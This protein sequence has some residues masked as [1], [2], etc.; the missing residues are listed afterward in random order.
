MLYKKKSLNRNYLRSKDRINNGVSSIPSEKR[1]MPLNDKETLEMKRRKVIS[2][3]L[4]RDER[5]MFR[6]EIDIAQ[7]ISLN[8]KSGKNKR[9]I[10]DVGKGLENLNERK[11]KNYGYRGNSTSTNILYKPSL[12][13]IDDSF[14][15]GEPS[16]DYDGNKHGEKEIADYYEEFSCGIQVEESLGMVDIQ[17]WIRS[18]EVKELNELNNRKKEIC[19]MKIE[20]IILNDNSAEENLDGDS[21]VELWFSSLEKIQ[22]RITLSEQQKDFIQSCFISLLPL[23]Y[24]EQFDINIVRLTKRFGIDAIFKKIFFE[25]PRRFGKTTST[26]IV[27]ATIAYMIP[28]LVVG[29]YSVVK[30][31]SDSLVESV[32][33][34]YETISG[35]DRLDF[36]KEWDKR[37]GKVTMKNAHGS[38]STVWGYS[39][40]SSVSYCKRK[41]K[42]ICFFSCILIYFGDGCTKVFFS[43]KM[44]RSCRSPSLRL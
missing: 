17:D 13:K 33:E 34:Y 11:R 6:N 44:P 41:K 30:S 23:I 32:I 3:V 15:K 4:S 37:K 20:D 38:T 14:Q 22:R 21:I 36:I 40:V 12:N 8:K 26:A 1:K 28:G 18:I 19:P 27:A 10:E 25:M 5:A 16:N 43:M 39:A 7:K 2:E 42:K 29:I 31:A 35:M 9:G 24:G